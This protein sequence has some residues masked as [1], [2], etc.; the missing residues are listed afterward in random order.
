M[1][2]KREIMGL[3]ALLVVFY[4]FY[5]PF[6]NTSLETYLFRSTFIGVDLFFFVSACSLVGRNSKQ[7]FEYGKF[8]LNRL[9]YIY[10]PFVLL[11]VVAAVYK[12]WS[13][14]QFAKV[15]FGVEFYEKGGG[16][17]LWYFIGIMVI[18]L[19]IPL[20]LFVKDKFK[21]L[22]LVVLLLFWVLIACLIQFVLKK[23]QLFILVNRL[24]VFFVG[25]YYEDLIRKY[26]IDLKKIFVVLTELLIF[27][28]GSILVYKYSVVMRL[29]KPFWDIY[30]VLGLPL[31]IAVVMIIDSLVTWMDGKYSSKVLKFMGGITL[32]LYG[33]QMV[34]GYDIEKGIL[35]KIMLWEKPTPQLA[36]VG[37]LAILI[38]IAFVFNRL[39][40]LC[41]KVLK[42]KTE[43]KRSV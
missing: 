33:L 22:G 6:G 39:L 38:V 36:F 31:I 24:P 11:S 23:N 8:L 7:K 17:F 16:S 5:I 27:I 2:C 15:I 29:N 9:E 18:Y 43:F 14:I 3:A 34:F 26:Y 4:H 35:S 20:F 32:E 25:M 13:F 12:K 37:T 10:F 30:Y 28:L 42:N 1:R 21:G 40:N 41:H 19:L